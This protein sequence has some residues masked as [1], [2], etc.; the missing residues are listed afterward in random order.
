MEEYTEKVIQF[1]FIMV[2]DQ[3][4]PKK[5]QLPSFVFQMFSSAF[6]LAPLIAL[7]VNLIDL[8]VDARR[9]LWWNRRP[10]AFIAVDIG[11]QLIDYE[12]E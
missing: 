7:F 11:N 8:R 5:F 1:G 2:S 10:V 12:I 6:T 4:L 9:L 3:S